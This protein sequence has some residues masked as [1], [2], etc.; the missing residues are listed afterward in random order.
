MRGT[1]GLLCGAA[2]SG[3]WAQPVGAQRLEPRSFPQ[4]GVESYQLR[5]TTMGRTYDI[6]VGLPDDYEANP[7]MQY[8]ALIVT[9][10]NR[11]F[12]V[13]RVIAQGL[14]RM[15][16][17][18]IGTP[19]EEGGTAYVRRRVHEFSPPNWDMDDPFGRVVNDACL[20]LEVPPGQECTGGAPAFLNFIVS[21]LLPEL[22]AK[23]RID[24]DDLGL[25][26]V[27]AGGFFTVYTM[28]QERSPF[29]KY[30]ASSAAM[31]YGDDEIFRLE[32]QYAA[33][34]DDLPVGIYLGSG[35]L[36][37]DDAFLEG[38]GRISSGQAHLSG[39]LR[40]RNYPGLELYSEIHHGLGHADAAP[41]TL[42]R[43]VRLLY[44]VPT[45]S[46]VPRD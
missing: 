6:S 28:F 14:S 32:E 26:G 10:G 21:E 19:F 42:A 36:E 17:I 7:D 44:V 25:Y 13:V 11:F 46:Y 45:P 9:D 35:S 27:S 39:M 34:H 29:R 30:I 2:A 38:I 31:A 41:V 37:L 18:S 16:V 4:T 20:R 12:P 40:S 23:Y 1:L 24:P 5:S 8:P 43:G 22:Y 3:G 33:T 15:L